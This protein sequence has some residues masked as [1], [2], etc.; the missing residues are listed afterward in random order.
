MISRELK[1]KLSEIMEEL[2]EKVLWK[3][4]DFVKAS[5]DVEYLAKTCNPSIV[6]ALIKLEKY[7]RSVIDAVKHNGFDPE[8]RRKIIDLIYEIYNNAIDT[9]EKEFEVCFFGK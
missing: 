7:R 9:A 6:R 4:S 3:F 5:K 1:F 8:T 2:P